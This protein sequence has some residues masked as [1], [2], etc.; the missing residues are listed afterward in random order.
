MFHILLSFLQLVTKKLNLMNYAIALKNCSLSSLMH[1]QQICAC[2]STLQAGALDKTAINSLIHSQPINIKAQFCLKMRPLSMY[3]T[4]RRRK[5]EQNHDIKSNNNAQ[6]TEHFVNFF[7]G[8][9][10]M[11]NSNEWDER[12]V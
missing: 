6:I 4:E 1:F 5:K 9:K 8:M 11:Q 2:R 10:K 7:D 12:F 3:F